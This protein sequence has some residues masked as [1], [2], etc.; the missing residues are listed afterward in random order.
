MEEPRVSK[1]EPDLR[2]VPEA[3]LRPEPELLFLLLFLLLCADVFRAGFLAAAFFLPLLVLDFAA[4]FLLPGAYAEKAQQRVS[5]AP[6]ITSACSI[7][8]LQY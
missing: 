4:I 1:R 5:A 8:S 7:N 2:V 3:L 6:F